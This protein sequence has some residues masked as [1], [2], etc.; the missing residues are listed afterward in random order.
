M[1]AVLFLA[2]AC[3]SGLESGLANPFTH[4]TRISFEA[5]RDFG[6]DLSLDD[7][8]RTNLGT[9][10]AV[11]WSKDE[12]ITVFA[13]NGTSSTFKCK[14]LSDDS[15]TAVF[16]G[17]A[18]ISDSYYALSP[19]QIGA[20]LDASSGLISAELPA[21]QTAVAGSFDP[22]ASLAI[23]CAR[24]GELNFRNICALVSFVVRN[25]DI[26]SITLIAG[27]KD[28]T[29]SIAGPFLADYNNGEPE[30][31]T[32]G[33]VNEITLQ[34]GFSSGSRYY[35]VLMPGEYED[36][37]IVFC[38]AD[39]A[40]A[41]YS[42]PVPLALQR[43]DNIELIDLQIPDDKWVTPSIELSDNIL[44]EA[45]G[46][47]GERTSVTLNGAEG[48]TVSVSC[49][50]CVSS[51]VYDEKEGEIEYIVG[52]NSSETQ[53]SGSITVTISKEGFASISGSI[54]VVQE[55]AEPVVVPETWS[56][57][58]STADLIPGDIYVIAC[59]S[60][61]MVATDL[62]GVVFGNAAASFSSDNSTI[63]SLPS[64]AI[65][66]TLGGSA[67]AWTFTNSSNQLLG[68]TIVKKLAWSSGTTTWKITFS[69]GAVT[70]ASTNSSY[71]TL[72]YNSSSPRFTTYTSG[73]TDI[74]LYHKSGKRVTSVTTGTEA[75][76][77]TASSAT[78][79]ASFVSVSS[80]PTKAG[81]KYGMDPAYLDLVAD[82]AMPSATSGSYSV[83]LSGL[84]AATT[85]YY[86]AYIVVD[87]VTY[88]GAVRS[89]TTS[90]N[91][92][93]GTV[94]SGGADYGW[95]EL[96]AQT[97]KNRDGIDDNNSDYYY[98]HTFR[99]D[100]SN[101]RNF[102]SC[103]SKSMLHPVWVAAPMHNCYKGSTK[104][105]EAYKPDP[106]IKC[107]QSPKF[108]GYTRG[109]MVGS[110]DRTVSKPTNQQAFYYSNIGAQ[111]QT[112]FNN[113][114]GAWNN[115]EDR[116]D[117][118][119]C[120]DTLYQVIGCIFDTFTDKYGK[121]VSARTGSNSVG[122]FQVPTAWYKVLLRT[123]SGKTGK[124]VSECSASELQCVAFIL[125]HYSNQGHKPSTQD[126]YPVSKVEELTGLTF[127]VNVPN[128]P[129]N[130]FT[131][132]DWNF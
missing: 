22:A 52:P 94:S 24:D 11:L 80:A 14:S 32:D 102:S 82:A 109:H 25:D 106:N 54:S 84:Y 36:L 9:D 75:L 28:G 33:G 16:S 130:S 77:V 31:V 20:S 57:V 114:G 44:V 126:M 69:S 117:G 45:S 53:R 27:P 43:N 110:S 108:E 119:L 92:G 41:T 42:N 46:V 105:S 48:W 19:A 111:T 76:D 107:T 86:K 18:V 128:A 87:G 91:T 89:F 63:T 30:V 115:L 13:D 29:S 129:K 96:P 74:A 35:M 118:Y 37:Q 71:G 97:D 131:A 116:V 4:K 85:Y 78:V 40:R 50:G 12:T 56:K 66:L 103:Y 123:K 132:S 55:G 15:R 125:G 1:I 7:D 70:V 72:Q 67:G 62:D 51:A 61:G 113:G 39:G 8:T 93:G 60:K 17:S 98:S 90:I 101:I 3:S 21:V 65:E 64:S 73:Q 38:R 122:T 95:P 124:K 120:A 5:T 49:S 121:T 34:G 88:S 127:F 47:T 59:P 58:T 10:G 104:R 100:A 79:Q 112:G 2:A 68:C 26:N 83:S 81:F 23:A 99:A 6:L